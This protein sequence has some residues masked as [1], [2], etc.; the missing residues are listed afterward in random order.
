MGKEKFSFATRLYELEQTAHNHDIM[1][2]IKKEIVRVNIR[3]T[4]GDF[5]FLCG[6]VWTL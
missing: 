4:D 6:L 2:V 1:V 3:R 5:R